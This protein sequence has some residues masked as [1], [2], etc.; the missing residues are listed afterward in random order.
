MFERILQI[1]SSGGFPPA[2]ARDELSDGNRNHLRDAMILEAHIREGRD[3]FV[4]E[5]TKDF[6]KGDR[7]DV[8]ERLCQTKIV[9]VAEF[10]AEI[11][12]LASPTP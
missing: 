9:T 12:T 1:I 7:R 3:V 11:A 8:L 10:C 2:G 6:I 5:N 4:T